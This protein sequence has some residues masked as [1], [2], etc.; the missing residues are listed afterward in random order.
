MVVHAYVRLILFKRTMFCVVSCVRM[1]VCVCA[2]ARFVIV[3]VLRFLSFA[4]QY[5][6]RFLKL[7]LYLNMCIII[8]IV[9][10]YCHIYSIYYFRQTGLINSTDLDHSAA[11]DLG[12]HS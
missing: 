9:V 6:L 7:V 4:K 5:L 10:R 2:R 8:Y 11:S 1:C 12:L 3:V